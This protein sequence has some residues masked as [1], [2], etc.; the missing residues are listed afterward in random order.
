MYQCTCGYG[1]Q[2]EGDLMSHFIEC[3]AASYGIET[4]CPVGNLCASVESPQKG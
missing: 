4:C 2:T 1:A 3:H